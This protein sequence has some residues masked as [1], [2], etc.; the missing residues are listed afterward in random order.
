VPQASTSLS[1]PL[2]TWVSGNPDSVI[3]IALQDPAKRDVGRAARRVNGAFDVKTLLEGVRQYELVQRPRYRERFAELAGGQTPVALFITCA[4]SRVVPNLVAS[5][6]PGELF[7]VRN[8]ANLVPPAEAV[9][10]EGD[11][12]VSSA[13]WYALEVLGIRDIIVC[14][15]SG[16]G[17][18][19]ALLDPA[20]PRSKHL[21][22]W[23]APAAAAVARW[24]REGPLDASYPHH[25]QLSQISACHQVDNLL[26]Y[27]E[28]RSR[29]TTGE[30]R[31]HAWWFDIAAGR[32]LAYSEAEGRYIPAVHALTRAERFEQ[33]A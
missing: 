2:P 30:L 19:K 13:V 14:G 21:A 4:D 11:T 18:V 3:A 15:H 16:C 25:D 8:V 28:V 27:D 5:A 23:L 10:A 22:R 32:L 7:V 33:V 9:G 29:V 17:G 1:R 24:R 20:P 31:L 26:S 12:S 6:E